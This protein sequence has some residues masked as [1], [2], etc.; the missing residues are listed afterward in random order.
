MTHYVNVMGLRVEAPV[1]SVCKS[2]EHITVRSYPD[3]WSYHCDL[4]NRD[5]PVEEVYP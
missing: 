4:C 1:C 5:I 3:S 2:N